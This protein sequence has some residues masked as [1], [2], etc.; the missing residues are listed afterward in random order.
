MLNSVAVDGIRGY[1]GWRWIFI[2]EGLLTVVVACIFFFT[3]P[4]LYVLKTEPTYP[5]LYGP[6]DSLIKQN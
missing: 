2:L 4:S 5:S 6:V 1:H 3:F